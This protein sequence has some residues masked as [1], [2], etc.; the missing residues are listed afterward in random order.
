MYAEKC[1]IVSKTKYF[2]SISID[3]NEYFVLQKLFK[4]NTHY[5]NSYVSHLI[6]FRSDDPLKIKENRGKSVVSIS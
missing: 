4:G 2:H 1:K 5:S 6:G 3:T